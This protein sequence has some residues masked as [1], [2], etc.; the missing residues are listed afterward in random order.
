[1]FFWRKPAKQVGRRQNGTFRRS[2]TISNRPHEDNAMGAL[3][4]RH[5]THRLVGIRRR[6]YGML[7]PLFLI[8]L[9]LWLL[10]ANFAARVSIGVTNTTLTENVNT[11]NYALLVNDYLDSHPWARL[12]FL[13]DDGELKRFAQSRAP[14]IENIAFKTTAGIGE[15]VFAVKFREPVAGWTL[16]GG[17]YYVDSSGIS[18]ETNY[19]AEPPV[20]VVDENDTILTQG[21]QVVSDKFLSFVGHVVAEAKQAGYTVSN[22]KIPLNTTRQLVISLN[23]TPTSVKLSVDR[24]VGEQIEDMSR[25]LVYLD[26]N[27]IAPSYIDVRVENKAYYQ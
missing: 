21:S 17:K 7:V 20:M 16:G 9:T 22:A 24:S 23:E 19:F 26:Q 6:V 14:H 2:R 5:H 10:V 25:A 18:F 3:S 1:M 15:A 4:E 11:Q 27:N 12:S 13:I 8:C